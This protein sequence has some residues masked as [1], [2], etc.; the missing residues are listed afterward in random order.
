MNLQVLSYFLPTY[1]RAEN[2]ADTESK[3]TNFI[4]ATDRTSLQYAEALVRSS[5]AETSENN[6]I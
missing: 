1:S 2:I 6:R 4:Q 3:I 5:V